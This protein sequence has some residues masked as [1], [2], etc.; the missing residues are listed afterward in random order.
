VSRSGLLAVKQRLGLIAVARDYYSRSVVLVQRL[1]Q[2][3]SGLQ[4]L[5]LP[6]RTAHHPGSGMEMELPDLTHLAYLLEVRRPP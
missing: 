5:D 4:K 3:G 2:T 1:A 6:G